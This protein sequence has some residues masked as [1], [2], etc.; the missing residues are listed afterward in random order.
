[1]AALT[2]AWPAGW[3]RNSAGV[4]V[5]PRVTSL[6]WCWR[7]SSRR[8]RSF[9]QACLGQ[10]LEVV[11]DASGRQAPTRRGEGRGRRGARNRAVLA[12]AWRGPGSQRVQRLEVVN[13]PDGS[14][15][16]P[17]R[18]PKLYK[19][20]CANRFADI[21]CC[22]RVSPPRS[23]TSPPPAGGARS[24]WRSSVVRPARA[25]R[26]AGLAGRT[27]D[28]DVRF[29]GQRGPGRVCPPHPPGTRPRH[30]LP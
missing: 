24:E 15:G 6:H 13:G 25:N 14:P 16:V 7:R 11:R 26:D 28:H 4:Q 20:I 12:S 23:V 29:G 17:S 18:M 5:Y 27:G 1:M 22:P 19:K 10:H 2:V 3:S 8:P 30:Q 21:P 9:D